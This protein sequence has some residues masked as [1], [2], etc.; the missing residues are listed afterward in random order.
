M[1]AKAKTPQE[2]LE[3]MHRRTAALIESAGELN[4]RF[5]Q[6]LYGL[7]LRHLEETSGVKRNEQPHVSSRL[8][9]PAIA[10][11]ADKLRTLGSRE[12]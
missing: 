3:E 8:H 5:L 1:V 7:A 12:H 2:R 9:D 11:L 10:E 4:D 6:Y